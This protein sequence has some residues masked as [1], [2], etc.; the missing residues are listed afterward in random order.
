[1]DRKLLVFVSS[2]VAAL[3]GLLLLLIYWGQRS[4]ELRQD[5]FLDKANF[6]VQRVLQEYEARY[7]CFNLHAD[8]SLPKLD[9]FFLKHPAI[10]DENAPDKIPLRVTTSE[11]DVRSFEQMP[12]VGPAHLHVLMQFEF[13][14]IPAFKADSSLSGFERYVRETYKRYITDKQ[15]IRLLDTLIF[16][17][18]V[19]HAVQQ[20]QPEADLAYQIQLTESEDVVFSKGNIASPLADWD[21]TGRMYSEDQLV[22]ELALFVQVT[23]KTDLFAKQIWNV[24]LSGALLVLI[25]MTI[26][27]YL[28]RLQVQQKRL[29]RIQKDFVHGITHEFNTPISN[30]N[31][32]AQKLLKTDDEKVKKAGS[33]LQHEGRKLQAGINLVLTT[34][35]I[36][37]DELLLDFRDVDLG[38]LLQ[39]L[40]ERN[41]DTLL[42]SGIN[43]TLSLSQESILTRG[44]AFHLENVFQ[45]LINN[46]I[47]HSG[48]N[49]LEIDVE[50]DSEGLSIRIYDNGKGIADDDRNKIF[51][52]FASHGNKGSKNGY[53]LGLY[54]SRMIVNMHGGSIELETQVRK[55]SA[56]SIELP[57]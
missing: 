27:F 10:A 14:D 54:Y 23:N 13:D 12:L 15:G 53:G 11:G 4:I 44:D 46:A 50:K 49:Q 21:V 47:K 18:L 28:I 2:L 17:S 42:E 3:L 45:S 40:A 39:E 55:G 48:A 37:K 26:L 38:N 9:S 5:L 33:I 56:F 57:T 25:S 24:Y 19:H 36:E 1:M 8:L 6:A 31:L 30:I 29:L 35:L 34:A 16:D 43:L 51:E 32:V 20:Y 52:K 22:P 41:R 7:Y